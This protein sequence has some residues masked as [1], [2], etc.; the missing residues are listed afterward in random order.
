[1]ALCLKLD[2][3]TLTAKGKKEGNASVK[4]QKQM[5][6]YYAIEWTTADKSIFSVIGITHY[7]KPSTRHLHFEVEVKLLEICD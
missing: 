2:E 3:V 1:M 5:Y 6:V 7:R 4:Q